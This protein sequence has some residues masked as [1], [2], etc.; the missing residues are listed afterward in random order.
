MGGGGFSGGGG[1]IFR[2]GGLFRGGT[3]PGG[4]YIYTLSV[5]ISRI[6]VLNTQGRAYNSRKDKLFNYFRYSEFHVFRRSSDECIDVDNYNDFIY[7]LHYN[8][9]RR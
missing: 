4:G 8:V 5:K 7:N 6:R 9:I 1:G 3:F 2:G